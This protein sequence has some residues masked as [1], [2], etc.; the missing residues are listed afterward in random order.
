MRLELMRLLRGGINHNEASSVQRWLRVV[1][2]GFGDV[3]NNILAPLIE[4]QGQ[5]YAGATNDITG[6]QIW[7]SRDGRQWENVVGPK[8]EIPAGFG[9]KHNQGINQF[10]VF[11]NWLFAGLWNEVDGAQLWVSDDG[12]KW[13][14][15]IGPG[16]NITGGFGNV[17]NR[18]FYYLLDF[19]SNLYVGTHNLK[20]GGELWRLSKEP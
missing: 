13:Q 16:C 8:T 17:N 3:Q 4:F 7:R 14:R 20:D 10:L 6:C 19:K 5:L 9:N 18:S 15:L 1:K 12:L 11:G 2:G